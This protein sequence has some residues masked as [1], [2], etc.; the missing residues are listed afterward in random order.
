MSSSFS[1][2]KIKWR[3]IVGAAERSA[4]NLQSAI[5]TIAAINAK[6]DIEIIKSFCLPIVLFLVT[7][8][9][10]IMGSDKSSEGSTPKK[11]AICFRESSLGSPKPFSHLATALRLTKPFRLARLVIFLF[12]IAILSTFH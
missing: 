10:S 6:N 12:L 8:T 1:V 7:I 2:S 4:K 3:D 9:V 11:T 5:K